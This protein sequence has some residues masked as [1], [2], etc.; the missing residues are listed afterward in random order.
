MG[1]GGTMEKDTKFSAAADKHGFV[2]AYVTLSGPP[3]SNFQ[4]IADLIDRI[5]TDENIDA[6]RV[7]LTGGSAGGS[8]A[9]RFACQFPKKIAA[10]GSV[11][12]IDPDQSCQ[13]STPVSVIEIHG[14]K[15]PYISFARAQGNTDHWRAVDKCPANPSTQTVG[16]MTRQTWSPCRAKTAVSLIKVEGGGHGWYSD[17]TETLWSF[18]EA[19]P[20]QAAASLSASM[21]SV[22]VAYKPSPRRLRFKLTTNED[23]SIRVTLRRS[24]RTIVSKQ[25]QVQA[26]TRTVTIV[27]PRTA[28]KGRY[29]LRV[30]VTGDNGDRLITRALRLTR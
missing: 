2:V 23:A 27:I 28:R 8:V 4:Y 9:Y 7:Y 30:S 26:G 3:Y 20:R 13:P 21:S 5:S 1:I 18:F 24:A 29:T 25:T 19:H 11:S 22:I 10:I 15:D 6:T 14:T 12:A 17:A 16:S